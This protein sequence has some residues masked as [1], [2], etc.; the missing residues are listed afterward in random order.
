MGPFF[1]PQTSVEASLTPL[2]TSDD[3]IHVIED[4]M[5]LERI[6]EAV[7]KSHAP[8]PSPEG[9]ERNCEYLIRRAA[10]GDN[11]TQEQMRAVFE[12]GF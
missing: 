2:S 6:L 8:Y 9:D 12:Y 5:P 11:P 10:L 3:A 4:S 1:A 7:E